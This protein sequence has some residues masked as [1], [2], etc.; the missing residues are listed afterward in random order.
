MS[1]GEADAETQVDIHCQDGR[2]P[3]GALS[4]AG[5]QGRVLRQWPGAG[6]VPIRSWYCVCIPCAAGHRQRWQYG[7]VADAACYSG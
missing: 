5:H 2:V 7:S 6:D 3:R 4:D 1:E